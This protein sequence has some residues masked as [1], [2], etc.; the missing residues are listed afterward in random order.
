MIGY[1]EFKNMLCRGNNQKLHVL[2]SKDYWKIKGCFDILNMRIQYPD[3]NLVKVDAREVEGIKYVKEKCDSIPFMDKFRVLVIE[4]VS[5]TQH[6]ELLNA[7]LE[8]V[9]TMPISSMIL[10]THYI[11]DKRLDYRK[12]ATVKKF[13]KKLSAE[14]CVHD[15]KFTME[16]LKDIASEDNISLDNSILTLMMSADNLDVA[17]NDMRKLSMVDGLTFEVARNNLC[18]SNEI[19]IFNLTDAIKSGKVEATISILRNLKDKGQNDVGIGINMLRA[20]ELLL[21][22]KQLLEKGLSVQQIAEKL[23]MHEYPVKLACGQCKKFEEDKLMQAVI[24]LLEFD[25]SCKLGHKPSLEQSILKI[26]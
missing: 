21:H 19:D 24:E 1:R 4:N 5:F 11:T 2:I 13:E 7:I 20:F 6:K 16:D 9:P 8:Y 17:R 22:S 26:M 3:F 10:L 23:K 25:V 14:T 15:P 18:G 12:D